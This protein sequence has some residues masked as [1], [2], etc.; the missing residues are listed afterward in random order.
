MKSTFGIRNTVILA[1]VILLLLLSSSHASQTNSPSNKSVLKRI[2]EAF[3]VPQIRSKFEAPTPIGIEENSSRFTYSIGEA[4]PESHEGL[5]SEEK[6]AL[7]ALA[8]RSGR[9]GAGSVEYVLGRDHSKGYLIKTDKEKISV[10]LQ[11]SNRKSKAVLHEGKAC[12]KNVLP[13]TDAVYMPLPGGIEEMFVIWKDK[14]QKIINEIE[15]TNGAI[16]LSGE[17]ELRLGGM[18]LS[19][20][21]IFDSEGKKVE[22]K[23]LLKK[24]GRGKAS[25]EI[26]FDKKGLT[27]PVLIDPVWRSSAS[28]STNRVYATATLLPNGKVL[29]AG[30]LKNNAYAEADYLN[31]CQLY[32]PSTGTW[33]STGN[34]T[35]ARAYHAAVLLPT[36]K[37]LVSGGFLYLSGYLA[38]CELYDPSSGIWTATDSMSTPRAIHGLV[39][40]N[41]G[42]VIAVGGLY[43][44][45]RYNKNS[46]LYNPSTGTWGTV[47]S[48]GTE[49]YYSTTTLLTNG[50]VLLAGGSS[51]AG[52]ILNTCELYNPS[53]NAW[54]YGA[55]M[56]AAKSV[57]FAVSL[58]DGRVLVGGGRST[59]SG[60][61][62]TCFRYNP[63]TNAW[64]TTGNLGT[65]RAFPN[66]V[67]L[68]DGKVL[69]T[70]GTT[71]SGYLNSSEIYNPSSGTWASAGSMG[72]ART[73]FATTLLPSGKVLAVGG[74]S[75]NVGNSFTGLNSSELFD[76]STGGWTVAS[77]MST[78]RYYHTATLLPNG[79][80]LV[81]GGIGAGSSYDLTSCELYNPSSGSW[82]PTGNLNTRRSNHTATLLPSGKVLVA[83][84]AA[85]GISANTTSCELYDP[86]SGTWGMTGD[87]N[88]GR[89]YHTATLLQNGKVLV[90]GGHDYSTPRINSCELYD[91]ST[92]RWSTTGNLSVGRAVHTATLLQNG[93]VLV[94]GGIGGASGA[95]LS[96]CQLYNPT[97]GTW[98]TTGSMNTAR[99]HH[100]ATM[101]LNGKVL[102]TGGTNGSTSLT[103]CQLYDPTSGTWSTTGS[104]Y[105]GR[106]DHTATLLPNGDVLVEGGIISWNSSSACELYNLSNATWSRSGNMNTA[107]QY[108]T[109]TLLP[110][111]R[112]LVAGG[113]SAGALNSCELARYTEYNYT[114]Y[115][116]MQPSVSSIGGSSSFP[117][118]LVPNTA[119]AIVGTG[120]KGISESSNGSYHNSATNY[121]RVY[122]QFANSGGFGSFASSDN[123]LDETESL[124]PMTSA[125][126]ASAGTSI[127]FRTP[128]DLPEGYYL[129]SVQSNAVPSEAKMVYYSTQT[130][131]PPQAP[132]DFSITPYSTT[133]LNYSWTD[134]SVNESGFRIMDGSNVVKKTAAAGATSAYETGLSV[135]TQYTRKVQ[136]WN[137]AGAAT[138]DSVAKYTLIQTPSGCTFETPS[139]TSLTV[140]D[141]GGFS[142]LNLGS[143]GVYFQN[144]TRGTNSGWIRTNTWASTGLSQNTPY[145]FRI[146]ARNGDGTITSTL[147]AETKYTAIAAA[148]AATW[149]IAT[150]SITIRSSSAPVN[151]RLG[152]SGIYFQNVTKGTNSGW[153]KT[154]TWVSSGLLVNT[155]YAFKIT[156]RNAEGVI[157]A[158]LDAGT[159]YT[160]VPAPTAMTSEALTSS[161]VKIHSSSVP[162]NLSSGLSGLY[163]KNVTKNTNSG[164]IKTNTW[165]SSSLSANTSYSF[166]ITAR[167]GDGVVTTVA[168]VGSIVT[169]LAAPSAATFDAVSTN[170]LTI[171]SSAVPPNLALGSTGISFEV[172]TSKS[173]WLKRNNWTKTGLSYNTRYF[174]SVNFRN[175][176]GVLASAYT[177][178][179][180]YTA[181][182]PPSSAVFSGITTGAIT[183][184]AGNTL[185][186]L[187]TG[188]S[189]VYFRNS[190]KNTN[191]GWLQTNSWTSSGLSENTNYRFYIT[192]RNSDAVLTSPTYD[193]GTKYS[194]IIR[195]TSATWEGFTT[196]SMIIHSSVAPANLNLG[197]SGIL[198][199]NT[200]RGTNSG[201][202]RTNTWNSTGLLANTLYAYTI[203]TRNG[204][205]LLNSAYAVGS[206]YSAV[207]Q[208]TSAT[209]ESVTSNSITVHAG[210]SVSNL[211]LG[212]SGIWFYN[213][214]KGTNSGWIK[215]NTWTTGSLTPNTLHS[216]RVLTRNGNSLQTSF[217]SASKYTLAAVPAAPTVSGSYDSTDLYNCKITINPN[218]NPS[219]TYFAVSPDNGTNWLQSNGTISTTAYWSTSTTAWKYRALSANTSYSFKV[220]A[221]NGENIETAL[222][223][224]GS[225]TTPP[226][227]PSGLASSDI[228]A[229]SARLA[230]NSVTAA[231]RYEVSMG[232]NTA[233]TNLGVFSTTETVMSKTGLASLK[234][235][236]WFVRAVST[237][238]GTGEPSSIANFTTDNGIPDTP[239]SFSI[240]SASASQL[241]YTWVDASD[242][243]SGFRILD[244]SDVIKRL[245]IAGA[246][247]TSETG[248]SANMQYSRKIQAYS[249]YGA[250]TSAAV[251]KYTSIEAAA[252]AT[253]E[254]ITLNGLTIHSSNQP[255]NLTS[256][257]SGMYFQ[258]TSPSASVSNSGWI[259]TNTWAKTGLLPNTP[260]TYKITT[261]NGD[262]TLSATLPV[263]SKY[264]SI[265]SVSS[266][267]FE[268]LAAGSMTAHVGHSLTNLHLGSSGIW[269]YND[270]RGTNSGWIKTNTW[271]TDSLAANTSYSFRIKTR[272]ANAVQTN[273]YN[274]S[275]YSAINPPGIATYEALTTSSMR[276]HSSSEPE[277]LSLGSSGVYFQNVTRGTNSGWIRT[278]TWNSTGLNPNTRYT[279]RITA[280]NGDGLVT[281]TT[282]AGSKYTLAA[283]PLVNTVAGSYDA[284]YG[285]HCDITLNENGNPAGRVTD[286]AVT[287]DNGSTWLQS[288]GSAS[289]TVYWDKTTSWTYKNLS[290][291]TLYSFK[292]K[293]RNADGTETELSSAGS[294]TTPPAAPSS[295][296]S[297]SI[298]A[299]SA[300]LSWSSSAGAN[301]YEVSF[302]T[303]AAGTNL[304]V[305]STTETVLDKTGLLPL[306]NY[307]WS[308]K[309]VSTANGTG[310]AS[311]IVPFT[312]DDGPPST[313][314]SFSVAPASTSQFNYSWV[315][316]SDNESGFRILDGSN[317]VK[318]LAVAGATSTSESGLSAN[319]QYA[320]KVQAYSA[321]GAATSA[322]VSK[323]TSI[324]AVASATYESLSSSSMTVHSASEPSN[325]G[326]G[327]SGLYFIAEDTIAFPTRIA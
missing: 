280:R 188:S 169:A 173:G 276:V 202:I 307:Y 256:G 290:S 171:H 191:S 143:S 63:T 108:H 153:I 261:R 179:T 42:N 134:N 209:Y 278:N 119:Y 73:Y 68:P 314:E 162:A 84:G 292:A 21:V 112:V 83:G 25:V 230:W 198:F 113:S 41:T 222:S 65:A 1:A 67:L 19:R 192:S 59:A 87:L 204:D 148:T 189:G 33:S 74:A 131:P 277:N 170:A 176:T 193:A 69:I 62:N 306:R 146:T 155:P 9:S 315:D 81:A 55:N 110:S 137:A 35:R 51:E 246:T 172:H 168:D 45:V 180:P 141:S 182:Q 86:T 77:G 145:N 163:F 322:A 6:Q 154:N 49:R 254:P 95:V 271:V 303:N 10:K 158:T 205:G 37:V 288:D 104:T 164:W 237:A 102:V 64:A 50:K 274:A 296:T 31:T 29:V 174:S 115:S 199:S 88:E 228:T 30:G 152:Q 194:A 260:Y 216:F 298:T 135:N 267:T 255:S 263:S 301:R 227:K 66:S 167:N 130:D 175:Q 249:S 121:P 11:N 219:G 71:S 183:I 311:S 52:T 136:A 210:H 4:R 241:N 133:R 226:A 229:Y 285:Y 44:G 138:S 243:E 116:D 291:N 310:A 94:A 8:K 160:A 200:T 70:G 13:E 321:Y 165:T 85:Y 90:A 57:H 18:E 127:S 275:K 289:S 60:V 22:G 273:F 93:K 224:A 313:P 149:E 309:A 32:D 47:R 253:F 40:L 43:T 132:S 327:D 181:I 129:L 46:E 282:E 100:S 211:H 53:T 118:S 125:Q 178:Y 196:S 23:Y 279:Y 223:S 139:T 38:S 244:G 16:E 105:W 96:S 257:S 286:Y 317:A 80:V 294:D 58:P 126:W 265:E 48:L 323:Y 76:P 75:A 318:R 7:E 5:K 316:A 161:S 217:Y 326:A 14:G 82:S 107:R 157:T 284:I 106:Y 151:L 3:A 2:S 319:T 250:S 262:G 98:G 214:T 166:T 91:P 117:K 297:S 103:S 17:G 238:N 186:N 212:G 39:L 147:A 24:T 225:D 185:S 245:A 207:E 242:N 259:K 99:Y 234:K 283:A 325:L 140:H 220:K 114:T 300:R 144:T 20:P 236:Y 56:P 272:N 124:Y 299:G 320:R 159:K 122:L 36:G 89:L 201:W 295:P 92:G 187:T 34:M 195:P 142:R 78:A 72:T 213:D 61:V 190:T 128:S 197:S 232:T 123:L 287:P 231:N 268:S 101:L 305:T 312:T 120:L 109:A 270:T 252:S 156:L 264:T 27:F 233:G 218:S 111:G 235:Y 247:S 54:S 206:K 12:Y 251:S 281:S 258:I 293:A 28:M 269:F 150:T 266:A 308:V 240:Y 324:E 248:L 203:T 184:R 215:T 221:R 97:S 79:K 15:I 177:G 26:A 304:G 302:G 239:E 208:V